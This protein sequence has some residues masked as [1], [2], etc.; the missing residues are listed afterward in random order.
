MKIFKLL[1]GIALVFIFATLVG[2]MPAANYK[3]MITTPATSG[4]KH[5]PKLNDAIT[6]ANVT[7]GQ[8]INQVLGIYHVNNEC[9][10]KALEGSLS[11]HGYFAS[12]A[13]KA[14]YKLDARLVELDQPIIGFKFDITSKI[15][16]TLT[17]VNTSKSEK[18]EIHAHGVAHT[19]ESFMASQRVVIANERAIEE[20][21]KKLLQ[22]LATFK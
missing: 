11:S 1:S 2:C 20:N 8:E 19:S 16:Y 3:A 10:K 5:N 21:I 17:D 9:I 14:K 13:D 12:S 4:A 15:I 6:V 22:F 7:G 18:R